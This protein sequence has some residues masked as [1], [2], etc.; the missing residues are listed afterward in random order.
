MK[1]RYMKFLISGLLISQ[2]IYSQIDYSEAILSLARPNILPRYNDDL[3]VR[4]VSSY[5][6]TGG[7]DDGFSGRYSYLRKEGN[8]LVIAEL[9]G[10]GTIRRMWTP[11]PTEDTI[12]FYFD[13]EQKPRINI[14][15]IELFNGDIYPFVRPVA[16]NEV[17]GYYCYLPVP[18]LKS[19]KIILK[20]KVM[21]FIQIDYVLSAGREVPAASFPEKLSPGEMESLAFVVDVWKSSGKKVIDLTGKKEGGIRATRSSVTLRPGETVSLFRDSDSGRLI[22][23][24]IEPL[25]DFNAS[26]KD[27]L[28]KASWDDEPVPAINCPVT[29]FFGYAFGKPSMQSMLLGV[30][31]RVHYCFIPM[32]YGKNASLELVCFKNDNVLQRNITCNVTVYTTESKLRPDEG[33]FYAWWNRDRNI[34]AGKPH[35]IL[36]TKGRGH[37]IGTLLQS[38]GLNSGMTV[39][40]EGDDE[41]YI[42][43]QLRLHGTGSEDYFNGGWYALPDRW[44]QA[45]SLPVHGSL[46]YS[47][48]LARTGGYRFYVSDKLPFKESFKLTI[49]HGGTGNTVPADYTSVAFF[50]SDRPLKKNPAPSYDLLEAVRSPGLLEYW[51]QLLPVLAFSEQSHILKETLADTKSKK[52]YEVLKFSAT[53][54]GF[55]K[56]VLNVPGDGDYNL[57]ISYFKGKNCGDFQVNQRQIPL[58]TISGFALENTFVEKEPVGKISIKSGTNTITLTLKG[59]KDRKAIKSIFVH[60]LYLERL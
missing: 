19:C 13:G 25:S 50:Y 5:D 21:Q 24:E 52:N 31:D 33:K 15:F 56:L 9:K 42:D 22:G 11:T 35:T 49:E 51:L 10:P 7:N 57:Y 27:V 45:F 16:G 6:I 46:E 53:E 32:P 40:F 38:Q 60:R 14:K 28:L 29:D 59:N 47:V 20:G 58:K 1:T 34:A 55:I 23:F 2:A 4:Q 18:F 44:D 41:C 43:G 39:F 8:N 26:F 54:E 17:G 30:Y 48:P 3:Q 37:Y 36:D 12:Q